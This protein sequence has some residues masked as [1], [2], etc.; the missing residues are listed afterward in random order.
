MQKIVSQSEFLQKL[1]IIERANVLSKNMSFKSKA[2]IFYRL[3]KLLHYKEMG[4]LFKVLCAQ[5]KGSKF[6]LG[7]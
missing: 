6:F 7:F 3:Q 4:T 2:D 5:K 1:G